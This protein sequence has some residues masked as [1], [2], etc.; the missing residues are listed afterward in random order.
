MLHCPECGRRMTPEQERC[1]ACRSSILETMNQTPRT[2]FVPVARFANAAEAGYFAH[3][4]LYHADIESELATQD[5]FDAVDHRWITQF[6]LSVPEAL[7]QAAAEAL[8]ALVAENHNDPGDFDDGL[9]AA[10]A[11]LPLRSSVM[12]A[13]LGN[14]DSGVNWV[15]IILTLAAGSAVFFGAKHWQVVAGRAAK[16]GPPAQRREDLWQHLATPDAPWTQPAGP[17][18]GTRQLWIRPQQLRAEL[19]EDTDGDG[20]FERSVHI[21]L[22]RAL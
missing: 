5:H 3:E 21:P 11:A 17:G 20:V 4:L 15:P 18:H 1:P 13:E 9:D 14:A 10:P 16:A 12:S 7:A 8:H 22:E 6:V 19:R 2:T